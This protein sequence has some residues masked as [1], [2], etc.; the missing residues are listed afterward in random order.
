MRAMTLI[1]L[2][3]ALIACDG[4]APMEDNSLEFHSVSGLEP[5]DAPSG[6][7][8]VIAGAEDGDWTLTL[9]D[10]SFD[11]HS[12]SRADLSALAGRTLT[13]SITDDWGGSSPFQLREGEQVVFAVETYDDGSG[14]F[15]ET[16]WEF[17][18]AV[19]EGDVINEY[20]EPTAV[21]FHAVTIHADDGD[22]TALPGEPV[23]VLLDGA[24]WRL[25]VVASYEIDEQDGLFGGNA[26][27]G[28]S[29]LLSV[30]LMLTD[31]DAGE[32]LVRPTGRV[33]AMQSCG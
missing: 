14:L 13:A 22:V 2:P 16:R 12:P 4:L 8:E 5:G 10:T 1:A 28:P 19:G 29:D 33:A 7:L 21:K 26:K 32:P 9:G 11:Y 27:C 3:L 18:E 30:E 6:A 24:T 17:G 31:E 20:D 23:S 25:T 15:G